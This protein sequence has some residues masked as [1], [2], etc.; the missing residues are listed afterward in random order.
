MLHQVTGHA[1][2]QLM[3]DTAK[4][5]GVN[6]TGIVTKVLSCSLEKIWQKN[7]PKMNEST[8]KTPGERMYLDISSMKDESLGGRRHW[9]MLVDE[10]TRCKN[11]FFLKKKSDQVDMVSSWLKGLKDKYKI[12]VKFIRCDNA[13]EN[14]KLEEKCDAEGLGI[15]FE[16]TASVTPQQNAY[17]ERVFPTLMARARAMMN[18]AGFTKE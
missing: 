8:A 2:Q 3:T 7:I 14:K 11:S 15:I 13:G 9:A 1:G 5:Y 16:Y 10:A 17:V 18:F 12:Q 4:Y 6:V